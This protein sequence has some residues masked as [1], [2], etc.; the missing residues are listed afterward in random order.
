MNDLGEWFWLWV[1]HEVSIKSHSFEGLTGIGG[2]ASKKAYSHAWQVIAWFWQE[3]WVSGGLS[4]SP[5]GLLHRA[6]WASSKYGSLLPPEVVIQKR[7]QEGSYNIVYVLISQ[8]Q[9]YY[10]YFILFYRSQLL[11][12]AHTQGGKCDFTFWREQHQRAYGHNLKPAVCFSKLATVVKMKYDEFSLLSGYPLP[13]SVL[14]SFLNTSV[15]QWS[16]TQDL[17]SENWVQSLALPFLA[18]CP[19]ASHLISGS[20]FVPWG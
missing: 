1:S 8:L 11:S 20:F 14:S 15:V 18:G 13:W 7:Q 2:S 17:Q 3:A 12:T 9:H 16:G 4:S 5:W 19:Q 6:A 10:F